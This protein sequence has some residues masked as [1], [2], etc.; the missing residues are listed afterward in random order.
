LAELVSQ[1]V[2]PVVILG[3]YGS[4]NGHAKS[5]RSFAVLLLYPERVAD[6]VGQLRRDVAAIELLAIDDENL[7][8]GIASALH[9]FQEGLALSAAPFRGQIPRR[10]GD[11]Q[12]RCVAQRCQDRVGKRPISGQFVI[13]PDSQVLSPK[14]LAHH[15]FEVTN[16]GTHPAALRS[17]ERLVIDVRVADK[18]VMVIGGNKGHSRDVVKDQARDRAMPNT[19]GVVRRRKSHE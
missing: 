1:L 7:G 10:H 14:L 2:Y 3:F 5:A 4:R 13:H 15:G 18:Y 9:Q 17:D 6:K 8:A 12:R 11:Q 19:N 16:Q